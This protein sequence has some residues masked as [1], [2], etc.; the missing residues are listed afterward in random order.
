MRRLLSRLRSES[1]QALISGLILLIA[2][3]GFFRKDCVGVAEG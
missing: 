2:W 1:G 3:A